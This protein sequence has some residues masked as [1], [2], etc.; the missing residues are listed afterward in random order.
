M[1]FHLLIPEVRELLLEGKQ[2]DLLS[3][4]SEMH[5]TD[6]ASILSALTMPEIASVLAMLPADFERD[7]FGYLEPDVQEEYITGIGRERVRKVLQAMLS[8]DRAAFLDRLDPRVR[9]Q[10]IPLLPNAAR[11]DL[12]RRGTF[13]ED[14]VGSFL[15]TDYAV[16]NPLLTARGAIAELRRQAPSKETIYYSYVLDRVGT[17]VG[18]VSLRDLI[19]ANETQPVG[20]I[21]KTDLVSIGAE[22]DQEEAARIIRDYDLIALPVVDTAGRLVGIVTHDDAVDIVEEEAQEDIEKMAG[23]TG[24]SEGDDFLEE[25]VLVQLRRR[26]PMICLLAV[27]WVVTATVI[28]GFEQLL[29]HRGTLVAT[30]GMVMAIGGM[31]GSQASTLIIRAVS[32]SEQSPFAKLLSKELLVSLGLAV[33]LAFIAFGN[34]LFLQWLDGPMAAGTVATVSAM[35]IATVI[36]IAMAADV[37]FAA[38]LGA[39]IPHLVKMLRIDPALIST[40]AVTALTDLTGAS[41]YLVLVTLML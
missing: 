20:E 24:A 37:V 8:D 39:S 15:T 11:E 4:L 36:G 14:Q 12:L 41:I 17:L 13:R 7:V 34:A 27:F 3:V 35:R 28:K 33:A 40:P 25:P 10:L 1:R 32:K 6:A 31:V 18:F 19:L 38:M 21:M 22:A 9:D 26:A 2:E 29:A 16:L 5:P 30:M 23:V